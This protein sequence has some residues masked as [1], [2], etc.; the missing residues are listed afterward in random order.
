LVAGDSRRP[1]QT[2]AGV[3]ELEE[4][5]SRVLGWAW[6]EDVIADRIRRARS[7]LPRSHLLL[8]GTLSVV[9]TA[10]LGE[11]ASTLGVD[12]STITPQA[13]RLERDGLIV[14]VPDPNDR[15][16]SLLTL[17]RSGKALLTR[18]HTARREMLAE[19]FTQWSESDLRKAAAG[20]REVADVL[21]RE[22]IDEARERSERQDGL[23]VVRPAI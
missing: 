18:M 4:A 22:S 13:Q 6:R 20:L 16:A 15:R 7:D 9:G 3:G 5:L 8:L 1:S 17:S 19:L 12:N 21:D 10:R 14:R 11:L 23:K 2:D